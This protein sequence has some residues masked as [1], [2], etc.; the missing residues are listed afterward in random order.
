VGKEK[1]SGKAVGGSC[2]PSQGLSHQSK[3]TQRE[4]GLNPGENFKT[5]RLLQIAGT[6]WN[7]LSVG[8]IYIQG[9]LKPK[10]TTEGKSERGDFLGDSDRT[11]FT[12]GG[13]NWVLYKAQRGGKQGNGRG[14]RFW[15]VLICGAGTSA[16]GAQ[17]EKGGSVSGSLELMQVAVVLR[18]SLG[19]GN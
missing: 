4:T 18:G 2:I 10:R 15:S 6:M 12:M 7:R 16:R 3:K 8:L 17:K 9:G 5:K 19:G 11:M 1:C 13:G 14:A